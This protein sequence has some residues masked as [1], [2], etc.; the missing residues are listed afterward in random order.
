MDEGNS[1]VLTAQH[2][3]KTYW[4]PKPVRV[5]KDVSLAV[6]R[7]QS[8]A[9]MGRSGEG[10]TTLLHILG[11]L[12]PFESGVLSL[13]NEEVSTRNACSLRNRH[14]GF[15][16]QA[17]HLLD[18]YT[19]LENILMPWRIARRSSGTGSAGM[20][21]ALELLEK[22]D[23]SHRAHFQTKLLSGGEKQRIALARALMNDP[24]VLLADEPTGNLDHQ[25]S[26]QIQDLLFRSC[27]ELGKALIVATHD[28]ALAQRCH[29]KFLLQD[30][31][32]SLPNV[33]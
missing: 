20:K 22:V 23:L 4:M 32:L 24:D 15:V 30:G 31:L 17:F 5:L 25:T 6:E 11:T 12:E 26:Q 27:E 13:A 8:I 1:V 16:F 21:R 2:L 28:I 14:I 7:G 18:H 29:K 33:I 9:I 19:A 3:S 10:K